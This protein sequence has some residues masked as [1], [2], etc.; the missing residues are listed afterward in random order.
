MTIFVTISESFT[1]RNIFATPFWTSFKKDNP[2]LRIVLLVPAEKKDHY[3]KS[4]GGDGVIVASLDPRF[5]SRT[6]RIITSLMRSA[7]NSH[8]NLWSKMRAYQRGDSTLATTVFKRLHTAIFGNSKLYKNFLRYLLLQMTP[9]KELAELYDKYQP[10]LLFA[11]SMTQFDFEV[12]IALEARRRGIRIIGMVRSWDNLS[13]HGLLRVVPDRFILQNEFLKKMAIENQA[14]N[15]AKVPLDVIGL[16]HYDHYRDPASLLESRQS[17]FERLGLDPAKKLILYG[18]MGDFLFPHEGEVADVLEELMESKKIKGN[19]QVIFR[20]HPKFQS[21]FERMKDMKH[22][23]PDRKATYLTKDLKSVE[24]EEEDEKHLINS[25]HHSDLIIAGASTIA[26]D[27]CLFDKP[28]ICVGFD[29]KREK[30]P[31]WLSVGRFYDTYTHFEA[32]MATGAVQL[33]KDPDE[34]ARLANE[35]LANPSLDSEKRKKAIE[36]LASPFDGK[37]GKRLQ[38]ILT[39]EVKNLS[40]GT[41]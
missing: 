26:L 40:E 36:L 14:I 7:I 38:E 3:E 11:S 16:P 31:Y 13:S 41:R 21:P 12:P 32:F 15:P 6:S 9:A 18:A 30:V 29:G 23:K 27:S 22:V 17:F 5:R 35:Y 1:A 8:T 28:V 4:F 39:E 25:I 37:A 24:I 34:L 10:Q 20:A 19:F 33:A 2:N